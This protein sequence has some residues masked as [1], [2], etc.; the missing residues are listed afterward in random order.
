MLFR[1]VVQS[2]QTLLISTWRSTTSSSSEEDAPVAD[3]EDTPAPE[4]D[5]VVE[6]V[7]EDVEDDRP[8]ASTI[9]E[10][11]DPAFKVSDDNPYK[12]V[13]ADGQA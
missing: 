12:P 5:E 10:A 7:E 3:S 6:D 9:E 13:P 2:V 8:E 1:T 4:E 11:R